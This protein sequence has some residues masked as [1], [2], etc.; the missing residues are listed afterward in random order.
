MHRCKGKCRRGEERR[1]I[2]AECIRIVVSSARLSL[3]SSDLSLSASCCQTRLDSTPRNPL[4]ILGP[5][6]TGKQQG[7]SCLN[8]HMLEAAVKI[9][10]RYIPKVQVCMSSKLI[11][12]DAFVSIDWKVGYFVLD[13]CGSS[14]PHS[15]RPHVRLTCFGRWLPPKT[16]PLRQL[17]RHAPHPIPDLPTKLAATF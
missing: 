17:P 14:R 10:E 7:H 6:P 3:K 2:L 15:G 9:R 11:S 12:I 1:L 16:P 4:P 8:R 5:F 13:N